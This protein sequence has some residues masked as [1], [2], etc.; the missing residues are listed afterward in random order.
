[1][2][3][4]PASKELKA[5]FGQDQMPRGQSHAN[6]VLGLQLNLAFTLKYV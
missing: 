1:M 4:L 2:K 5:G 6:A 3:R